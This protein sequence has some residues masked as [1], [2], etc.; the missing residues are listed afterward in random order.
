MSAQAGRGTQAG[1][2]PGR[3]VD[4]VRAALRGDGALE[5]VRS[6]RRI[7]ASHQRGEC[8]AVMELRQA[9]LVL[10]LEAQL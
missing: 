9:R 7:V 3:V 4:S 6:S 1:R 5:L 2:W 10:E 8:V